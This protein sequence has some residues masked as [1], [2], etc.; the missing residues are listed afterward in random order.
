MWSTDGKSWNASTNNSLSLCFGVAWNGS[1]WVATGQGTGGAA[2]S[3]MWSTDGKFWNASTNNS[4]SSLGNGIAWNGSLWVAAG[5][6]GGVA[7][8]MMWSTDGKFW[9]ASA[10][11]TFLDSG[12]G[13]A[14]NGS[15]WVAAGSGLAGTT[16]LLWSID[17]KTWNQSTN[18]TFANLGQEVAWNGSLW[19]A[20]GSGNTAT[21][22]MYWSTDGKFW[23]ASANSTFSSS[24]SGVASAVTLPFVGPGSMN[25][26][27]A[28]PT[29]GWLV[30]TVQA[31]TG[32]A[33]PAGLAANSGL[34]YSSSILA[35][36]GGLT[37][38]NGY[39]PLYSNVTASTLTTGAYGTHYNITTSAFAALILGGGTGNAADY[40]A[41][42]VLR[43]NTASYLKI[44]VTYTVSGGAPSNTITIP[45]ATSTTIMFIATTG[46][47]AGVVFF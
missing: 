32:N 47:N 36:T 11:N 8:S 13:V 43:N 41:Y 37:L 44:A 15:L 30:T 27:G 1:L 23:N 25:V 19:V 2:G 22:N 21:L 6:G 3:M 9:N 12:R 31:S 14:W 40:N 7:G 5:N 16:S 18:N 4:F 26:Q 42:W 17:G 38:T 28:G 45:P 35:V 46:G 29:G 24:G 33:P 39:R 20:A 34:T 10:N